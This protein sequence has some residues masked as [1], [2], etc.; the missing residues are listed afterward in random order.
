MCNQCGVMPHRLTLDT[1]QQRQCIRLFR[2]SQREE[3]R[4][5]HMHVALLPFL[6]P[7]QGGIIKKLVDAV[8]G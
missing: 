6:Q 7:M 4:P 2:L 3:S 1:S 8:I 5:Q